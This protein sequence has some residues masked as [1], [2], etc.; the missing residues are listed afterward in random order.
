V[1]LPIPAPRAEG[2]T[3]STPVPLYWASWGSGSRLVVLHGGPGADQRY[4]QPQLLHLAEQRET[5]FYDQ[6]GGGRSPAP[7][8]ITWLT[9][10]EDLAAVVAEFQLESPSIV[11][12]SWGALLA[13]LAAGTGTIRPRRLVLIDPAPITRQYRAEFEANMAARQQAVARERTALQQSGLAARDPDAYRQRAFELSVAGYFANPARAH[14]LTPFRVMGRVQQ[15]VWESLADYD[16]RPK[17]SNIHCPA[18]VVHGRQDPVPLAS[19]EDVARDLGAEL[20]AIDDCG[21]VPYVEQ[22]AALFTAVDRFLDATESD[23]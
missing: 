6:R 23:P 3:T 22:P 9:Q 15:S 2:F 8:A 12:F 14:D 21:H 13:L 10:V 17:L 1:P 19:S 11:G 4:L 7:G 16:I 18:L 5:L 20:V